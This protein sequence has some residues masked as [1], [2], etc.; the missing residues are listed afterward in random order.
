MMA[1][2][3]LSSF[4]VALALLV[5]WLCYEKHALGKKNETA[6]LTAAALEAE[7]KNLWQEARSLS[8]ALALMRAEAAAQAE[9]VAKAQAEAS[10]ARLGAEAR[11]R[12]LLAAPAPETPKEG[13]P[14]SV[15][16]IIQWAVSEA[17]KTREA[18]K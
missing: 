10:A 12:E 2:K 11:V 4:T 1:T 7:N 16:E 18:L 14:E 15:A 6:L 8:N 13:M 5:A 9:R 3:L 17:Q